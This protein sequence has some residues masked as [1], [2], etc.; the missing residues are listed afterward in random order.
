MGQNTS[1]HTH[2][3]RSNLGDK[4]NSTVKVDEKYF[5]GCVV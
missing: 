1:I 4:N 5:D 3:K 2:T